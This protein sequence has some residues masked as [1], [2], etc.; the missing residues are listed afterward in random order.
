MTGLHHIRS[1]I[2]GGNYDQILQGIDAGVSAN[3]CEAIASMRPVGDQAQLRIQMTWS[4][5]RPKLPAAV[6]NSVVFSRTAFEIAREAGRKL[7]DESSVVRKRIEGRIINLKA[8]LSLFDDF[9]GTVVLKVEVGG[10]QARVQVLLKAED[11]KKACDAHRDGQT[12]AVTGLLQR[13]SKLY[14]LLQPQNFQVVA[15]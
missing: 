4:S 2:D 12:V 11:Y 10:T 5:S 7:R 1:A 6:T 8:D 15:S 14:H 3:L 13:E 9:E